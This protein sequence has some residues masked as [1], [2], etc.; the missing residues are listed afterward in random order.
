MK[1]SHYFTGGVFGRFH[2]RD[3]GDWKREIGKSVLGARCFT[4]RWR[5][6]YY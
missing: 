6:Q 1:Q 3:F 2:V 5:V 4:A